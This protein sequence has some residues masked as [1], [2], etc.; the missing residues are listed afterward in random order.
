MPSAI[1]P[2]PGRRSAPPRSWA[3]VLTMRWFGRNDCDDVGAAEL[4][5]ADRPRG[6][7]GGAAES[8]GWRSPARQVRPVEP[9]I[10]AEAG[11]CPAAGPVR[12]GRSP[13]GPA[14]RAR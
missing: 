9:A 2:G 6:A 13:I 10:V 5:A 1:G 8:I 14:G 4:V 11:P 3:R 12:S 7:L